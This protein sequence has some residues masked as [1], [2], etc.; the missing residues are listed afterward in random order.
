MIYD[1]SSREAFYAA[2]RD[3]LADLNSAGERPYKLRT[4]SRS[5]TVEAAVIR[6]MVNHMSSEAF[7]KEVVP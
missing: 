2:M 4:G 5:I 3:L 1:D 7:P 6:Y